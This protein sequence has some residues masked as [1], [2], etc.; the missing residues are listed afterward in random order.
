M[1]SSQCSDFLILPG[2][3]DFTS[4]E[5]VSDTLNSNLYK[6]MCNTYISQKQKVRNLLYHVI[7]YFQQV[8]Y[9]VSIDKKACLIH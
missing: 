2:Y 9:F 6:Y 7:L 3:I 4:D 1:F 8:Y 5:V